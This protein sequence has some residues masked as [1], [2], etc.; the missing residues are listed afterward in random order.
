MLIKTR[1]FGEIDLAEDKIITFDSGLMGFEEYKKY[2]LLFD[3]DEEGEHVISWLQSCEE[4]SLALPV[5]IPTYVMPDY[6][7]IVDDEAISD[8][9]E[10]KDEDLSVL[11]TVT[12]PQDAKQ[13]TTNMK[14]P[15]I[16]NAATRKGCQAVAENPDYQIKYLV[17]D[18]LAAGKEE[19]C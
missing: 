8:I 4:E 1:Y 13:M 6:N 10:W 3:S 9:G 11:V 15:I 18:L 14:A 7:P 19:K 12:V 16:I 17:Y 2:T 5:M